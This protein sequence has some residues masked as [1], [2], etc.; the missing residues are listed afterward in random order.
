M[1]TKTF[2]NNTARPKTLIGNWAEE[3]YWAE[4]AVAG[5]VRGQKEFN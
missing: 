3:R 5:D 1:A 2:N 4:T